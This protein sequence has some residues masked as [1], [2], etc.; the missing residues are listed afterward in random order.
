VTVADVKGRVLFL[1]TDPANFDPRV[2]KETSSLA[3]AGYEVTVFGWDRARRHP[4]AE[5]IGAVAVRRSRIPAPYG[6]KLLLFLLPLWWLSAVDAARRARPSVVHACDMD[7][8][9]PAL[10]ARWLFGA[11]VVYDIFDHFADKISGV[12]GFV[13]SLL[14]WI[15][16]LLTRRADLVIVTDEHR[17]R[18][19]PAAVGVPVGIIMNVP[20][21]VDAAGVRTPGKGPVRLCYAGVI[22]EHRG[23]RLIAEAIGG[24]EGIETTFAGWIPRPVDADF[25]HGQPKISYIGKIPY[26]EAI[27][28]MGNSDIILALYDPAVPINRVASSNKVFEAMAVGVPVISNS[29]TTMA[30]LIDRI[31]CGVT[32]PYGDAALLKETILR[33]RDDQGTR[34]RMGGNG[35]LAHTQEF[36]WSVMESRLLKYYRDLPAGPRTPGK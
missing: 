23:L 4:A 1:R 24:I 6:S 18:L 30:G 19:L 14:R 29:E 33:L 10:A 36:N 32:I 2:L 25:L 22:H 5:R 21:L 15:D 27:K 26:A 35:R 20:P 31:S 17:R 34:V 13:R 16:G 28:L 11:R 9:V 8:L 12:P 3:A 7:A